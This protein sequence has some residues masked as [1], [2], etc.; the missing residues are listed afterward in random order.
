MRACK[1]NGVDTYP[2]GATG[3][4]KRCNTGKLHLLVERFGQHPRGG[5]KYDEHFNSPDLNQTPGFL[6]RSGEYEGCASERD[7]H[8]MVGNLHEWVSDT[9]TPTFM[10]KLEEEG[11]ERQE[12][13]WVEGNAMFMGGFYSTISEH[14]PGCYYTTVAHEP[15][16]HDY[17]TGFRCCATARPSAVK[18]AAAKKKDRDPG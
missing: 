6:A 10:E 15:R 14:G 7:V 13:P 4:R 11:V 12:Q 17:S 5:F 3:V 18:P 8:D 9:V 2:Y 16:Y 1:G